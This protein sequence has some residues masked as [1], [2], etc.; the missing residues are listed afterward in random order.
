[1]N[2][3]GFLLIGVCSLF[4]LMSV[5][6]TR[7]ERERLVIMA[8]MGNEP[9]EE[10]QM[11]HLLMCSNEVELE[12]LLAVGGIYLNP[13]HK[14]PK[15]HKLYPELFH[16][17]IDGYAKVYPNLQLH[18]KGWHS[19]DYLHSIV[20][21]GQLEYGMAG[22]GDGKSTEGSDWIIKVVTKD[23]PRPVHIIGN[24]GTS[25]LA[26]A[27]I[28]YRKNHT[29]EEVAAFVAK[30]RVYENQA[31]DNAG[32]WICHT[33]PDIHWIRG[34]TQTRCYGGP[35]NK[36]VGPCVWE[37]YPVTTKGQDD[38][39]QEHI[40]TGHGAL[41][42]LYPMRG[43]N[44]ATRKNPAFIEG[45]GTIPWMRLVSHG[46][47]DPN[48]PSWGGW[49]GRYTVEKKA[50]VAAPAK[51]V[52]PSEE[53]FKPWAMYTDAKDHWVDPQ[54]GKEYN[55]TNAGIWPWRR[56]MWND[57]QARMDWCVKPYNEANHH[58]VAALNGNTSDAIVKKTATV[59]KTLT[60]DASAST[61]PDGDTLRYHW[62][63]YPEAGR[64]PYGKE[65]A[66]ND[67]DQAAMSLT[68][69]EDAA[70]KE[71]H[72]ILEVWDESKIVPLVDYR[73]VVLII[74]EI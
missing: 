27:L 13:Q 10:Q 48:E 64:K 5:G 1:M 74:Q 73:R 72:L 17:L 32:A 68:I 60:F 30:L 7:A 58:P 69:P 67:S 52:R 6:E 4:S 41:G 2:T 19:P 24:A 33:Y 42:E 25:T 35:D 66:I 59:G 49:S 34:L 70:G 15:R 47:T 21:S 12:G 43:Y 54:T 37:P 39:A 51:S 3:R 63:I 55:D 53:Q 20:K 36:E 56:A 57:F 14:D 22:T 8:D 50:N 65:L 44:A 45:G 71:L 61:D 38:W 40:R 9:D 29:P 23:D 46:L 16:R 26:Q 28:D 11:L 62:W 31:Q 18:A